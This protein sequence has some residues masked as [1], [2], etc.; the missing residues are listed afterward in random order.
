MNGLTVS[1]PVK[2]VLLVP[3]AMTRPNAEGIYSL[4]QYRQ[5]KSVTVAE[6]QAYNPCQIKIG[7]PDKWRWATAYGR[8]LDCWYIAVA[9]Q[10]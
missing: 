2:M 3:L 9:G 8:G 4:S 5:P 6:W 1:Q 10:R 7:S